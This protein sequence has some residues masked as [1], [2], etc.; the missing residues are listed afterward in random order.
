MLCKISQLSR[1]VSSDDEN[2]GQKSQILISTEFP[3]L[4]SCCV[5]N[6]FFFPPAIKLLCSN[7]G[8]T[9]FPAENNGQTL[10]IDVLLGDH[11]DGRVKSVSVV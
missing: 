10:N 9:C 5:K 4:S 6:V 2:T 7:A 11:R 1:E 3:L 8:G